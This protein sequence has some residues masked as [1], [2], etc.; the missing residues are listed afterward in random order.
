MDFINILLVVVVFFNGFLAYFLLKAKKD[1]ANLSYLAVV[2]GVIFWTVSMMLFRLSSPSNIEFALRLLYFAALFTASPFLYFSFIIGSRGKKYWFLF[3]VIFIHI[4]FSYFTFFTDLFIVS[5]SVVYQG[6]NLIFFGKGYIFYS[7]YISVSF[8]LGLISLFIKMRHSKG[9][10]RSQLVIIFFGYF[11]ASSLAMFSNMVL[12]WLGFFQ[13]N[14]LGQVVSLFM[15]G[16]TVYA[17]VRYRFM[18]IR[19]FLRRWM[20]DLFAVVSVIA[21]A[22]FAVAVSPWGLVQTFGEIA[23]RIVVLVIGILTYRKVHDFYFNIANKFFF[24]SLHNYEIRTKNYVRNLP[25]MI[26]LDLIVNSTVDMLSGVM[27]VGSVAII[28]IKKKDSSEMRVYENSGFDSRTIARTARSKSLFEVIESDPEI[29]VHSEISTLLTAA[30]TTKR[31]KNILKVVKKEM[32]KIDAS[33]FVPII[34]VDK[35]MGIIVLS[36]KVTK[37]PY[38]SEDIDLLFSISRQ[39]S[40]PIDNAFLY[41]EVQDFSDNLKQKVDDQTKE[42]KDLYEMK[43]SFLTVASHQLRTPTSIIRGML[44]MLVEEDLP[45]DKKEEMVQAAY[46][47]SSNLERVINDILIAAE[48]DSSKFEI[49]PTAVDVIPIIKDVINDLGLK[50]YKKKVKLAFKLPRFKKAM[51][52]VDETKIDQVFYNL[53]DNAISYSPKGTVTISLKKKRVNRAEYYV[54]ECK[55]SGVGMTKSDMKN[56]GQKFFRSDN[57]FAI[58]PSGTGLGVFIVQQIVKASKGMLKFSSE[59]LGK[60]STF[61]VYMKVSK[62]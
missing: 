45:K 53:V 46:K 57:V 7:L 56:I 31:K 34:I 42:I 44:S 54:F 50:A 14:W 20:V 27:R 32:E 21:V 6:E 8:I 23:F 60:G 28:L 18:D 3:F 11:L 41:Q 58:R 47:S 30:S 51:C 15:T 29:F 2:L 4:I 26:D 39:A 33:V 40:V 9:R 36:E 5:G 24:T 37:E 12:P 10:R 61:E 22:L 48:I 19:I 43:S 1:L 35:L 38:T 13:L 52:F 62:K 17:I 55:D 59:G 16:L 25:T 49:K